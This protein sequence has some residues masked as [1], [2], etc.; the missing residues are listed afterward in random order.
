[1]L[2]RA[3]HPFLHWRLDLWFTAPA[4][5]VSHPVAGRTGSAQELGRSCPVRRTRPKGALLTGSGRHPYLP[6]VVW[7]AHFSPNHAGAIFWA[8]RADRYRLLPWCPLTWWPRTPGRAGPL[9]P[10]AGRC[11]R[12]TDD[13]LGRATRAAGGPRRRAAAQRSGQRQSRP[14]RRTAPDSICRNRG[15]SLSR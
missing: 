6:V 4:G 1:M 8:R 7:G 15:P 12:A 9:V 10:D 14:P 11:G 2:D 13:R 5:F 3:R